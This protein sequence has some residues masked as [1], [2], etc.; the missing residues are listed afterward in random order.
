MQ[1]HIVK[2]TFRLLPENLQ[3]VLGDAQ[4]C[5]GA[6][7]PCCTDSVWLQKKTAEAVPSSGRRTIQPHE[8]ST[9]QAF[10]A[11]LAVSATLFSVCKF[12]AMV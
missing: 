4:Q 5:T 7:A 11:K 8:Y 6:L 12:G 1:F 9:G 10:T 3:L 2:C